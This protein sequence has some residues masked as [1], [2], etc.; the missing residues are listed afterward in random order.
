MDFSEIT[1]NDKTLFDKYLK[2]CNPQASEFTFTNFF[3]WRY[4]YRFR[5]T[6]FNGLLC[7]IAVPEQGL[8]Y[9]MMPVGRINCDNFRK[10]VEYLKAYFRKNGWE[11]QFNKVPE[12]GLAYFKDIT[13][14][15]GRIVFDRDNCDYVYLTEELISL[16][17]KKFHAKRNH[18]NKFNKQYEY[19]YVPLHEGLVDECIRIM[20]DWCEARNCEC[21]MGKYCERFANMEVLNNYSLMDCKGALIK[22]NGRFEAFTV[23]EM[24]NSDTTVIHIEKASF[25]IDGLYAL[26][27]QQFCIN[28]WS[29]A[30]FINR[31]QDLGQEGLR[32]AKLSY[33]PVKMVNKYTVHLS[34]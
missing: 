1:I 7:I 13:C 23:G 18:I 22:V 28:E 9:A 11:L 14:S 10:T 4:Y 6:E 5:Y 2:L 30:T 12:D 3:M 20:H 8:P 33:N 19:E 29:T 24:L 15:E 34:P 26:V 21:W 25:G 27:N 16:S 31:E 17:G 32:K